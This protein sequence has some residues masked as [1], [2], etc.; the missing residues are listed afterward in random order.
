MTTAEC[1]QCDGY[2]FTDLDEAGARYSC[3]CCGETGR[4]PAA[5]RAAWEVAQTD[6]R[7]YRRLLP[8]EV[9]VWDEFDGAATPVRRRLL[10]FIRQAKAPRPEVFD[11]EDIPF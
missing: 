2:G 3:Y 4:V 9:L 8:P 6:G 10:P 5:D 1:Y 11:F 7:E